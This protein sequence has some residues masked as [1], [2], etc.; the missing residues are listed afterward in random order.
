MHPGVNKFIQDIKVTLS[1]EG[2]NVFISVG[3]THTH[4]HTTGTVSQS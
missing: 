2:K 3:N 1:F 4:T